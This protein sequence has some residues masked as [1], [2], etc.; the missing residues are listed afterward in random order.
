VPLT[1]TLVRV[2]PAALAAA[3]VAAALFNPRPVP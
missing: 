2:A 3:A 1:D